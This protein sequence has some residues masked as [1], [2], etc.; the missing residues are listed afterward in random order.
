MSSTKQPISAEGLAAA[1]AE[2]A[3]LRDVR[4]PEIVQ[5]IK[6]AREFGD[7]SENA[8]YHAAREAQ[9]LNEARIRTL[10]ERIANAEVVE[11]GDTD[12]VAVGMT[13]EFSDVDSGKK[14]RVTIV[15]A[16]EASAAEA[17]LSAESPIA[18]AL[19][20]ASIGDTVE[21]ETPKATK[22][23]EVLSIS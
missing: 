4:R 23:V 9:G 10:E 15:N 19:L 22:R 14:Q 11:A 3:E 1:E 6:S 20:G 13:V 16:L 2:L 8:E 18:E 17:K 7:L 21:I 12:V 5:S